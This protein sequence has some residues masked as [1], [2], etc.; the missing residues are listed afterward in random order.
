MRYHKSVLAESGGCLIKI[1]SVGIL[2]STSPTND[3]VVCDYQQV[4]ARL[5]GVVPDTDTSE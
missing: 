1:F 4:P 3:G 5:F 2:H